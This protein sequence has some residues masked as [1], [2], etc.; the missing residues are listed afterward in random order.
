MPEKFAVEA[1]DDAKRR[2][3]DTDAVVDSTSS[4]FTFI[5]DKSLRVGITDDTLVI[6]NDN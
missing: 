6:D 2:G 3:T 5:V 1:E 4:R